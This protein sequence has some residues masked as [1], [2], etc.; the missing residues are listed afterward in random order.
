[1]SSTVA[2]RSQP[3]AVRTILARRRPLTRRD[4]QLALGVLWLLDAALQAQ[5]FMFTRR[6]ATQLI[7]GVGQGQPGFV[8]GPV[9]LGSVVIA[10]SPVAWNVLFA[11]TQLLLG[12]G[13]LVRRAARFTLVASIGWALGI[14]YVGEG[15]SGMASGHASLLTG[16]PGSALLYAILAAAAWPRESSEKPPA[17]WLLR[18]WSALWIGGAILQ[19]L[20]PQSTGAGVAGL[21]SASAGAAPHWLAGLDTSLASWASRNGTLAVSAAAGIPFLVGIGALLPRTRTAALAAGLVLSIVIWIFGQDLGQVYS[22]QATDP[23]SAPLVALLAVVLIAGSTRFGTAPRADA[24]DAA[25]EQSLSR[26]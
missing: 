7:A 22:G 2:A 19:L 17:P 6:F 4:L 14:W 18:A 21:L 5:P 9:H 25:L 24:P 26:A 1:M 3:D 20:P 10:A 16:A 8:S 13:L 23:N 11:G 15:L 12:I